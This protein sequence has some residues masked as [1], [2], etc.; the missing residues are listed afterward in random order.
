MIVVNISTWGQKNLGHS[1][2]S[3]ACRESHGAVALAAVVSKDIM[4]SYTLQPP[5]AQSSHH[6]VVLNGLCDFS[7]KK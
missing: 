6:Y 1:T 2:K 5:K 3:M 4:S 7:Q